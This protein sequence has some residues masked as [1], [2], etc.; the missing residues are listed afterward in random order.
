MSSAVARC[1]ACVAALLAAPLLGWGI[2]V[3]ANNVGIEL[4]PAL[5]AGGAVALLAFAGMII[6]LSQ[7]SLRSRPLLLGSGGFILG[8][9]V[10]YGCLIAAP[11]LPAEF[12]NQ[13]HRPSSAMQRTPRE[14]ALEATTDRQH[15]RVASWPKSG[16]KPPVKGPWKDWLLKNSETI[17]TAWTRIAPARDWMRR[18]NACE[19][20]DDYYEQVDSPRLSVPQVRDLVLVQSAH[21]RLLLTQGRVAEATQEYRELLRFSAHIGEGSRCNLTFMISTMIENH[22]LD[23]AEALLDDQALPAELRAVLS[24]FL[25]D[26]KRDRRDLAGYARVLRSQASAFSATK[27]THEK[28]L[29]PELLQLPSF[30]RGIPLLFN[31]DD[32]NL[33]YHQAAAAMSADILGGRPDFRRAWSERAERESNHLSF[34]NPGGAHV[35]ADFWSSAARFVENEL[36]LLERRAALR[37]RLRAAD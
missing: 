23:V 21:L 27:R 8:S 13:N 5:V 35:V 7:A 4:L 29:S 12:A 11:A 20:Y 30:L 15:G 2:A 34:K 16:L 36:K 17:E 19:G 26:A 33:R 1:T 28:M 32:T 24:E 14:L 22:A 6:F 31:P 25:G 9:V 37:A 10:I 18:V 3:A